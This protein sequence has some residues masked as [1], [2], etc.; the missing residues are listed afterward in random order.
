MRGSRGASTKQRRVKTTLIM[1]RSEA[2][3]TIVV[4][5]RLAGHMARVE[6]AHA[7]RCG[8]QVTTMD[9]LAARLAGGFLQ[10]IE[11]EVLH[12]AVAAAPVATDLGPLEPIKHLPGMA[13]AAVGTLGKVWR[14]GLDLGQHRDNPRL[15][16]LA[17][18]EGAAE[19]A[20][21]FGWLIEELEA[22]GPR[23]RPIGFTAPC[24]VPR[25]RR[26]ILRHRRSLSSGRAKRGPVAGTPSALARPLMAL[27][28]LLILSRPRSG[29]VARR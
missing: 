18:L 17:A 15:M 8:V 29:R 27:K 21:L 7:G 10:P 1:G 19:P 24:G 20:A 4:H 12:Q 26:L 23:T 13:R 9:H 11:A 5:T 2:R 25:Q 16:A 22:K 3:R 6:A 28:S 14:A